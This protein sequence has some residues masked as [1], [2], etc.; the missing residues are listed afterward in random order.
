MTDNVVNIYGRAALSF[1]WKLIKLDRCRSSTVVCTAVPEYIWLL[2][3][4]FIFYPDLSL[5]VAA[6]HHTS[7]GGLHAYDVK[8]RNNLLIRWSVEQ[9]MSKEISL[10]VKRRTLQRRRRTRDIRRHGGNRRRHCAGSRCVAANPTAPQPLRPRPPRSAVVL[11]HACAQVS[12][13]AFTYPSSERASRLNLSSHLWKK[14]WNQLIIF[15]II[16]K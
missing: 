9:G 1:I 11:S 15:V 10:G 7:I 2:L 12:R 3:I 14:S 16:G 6:R 4:K 13:V 5:R 8:T